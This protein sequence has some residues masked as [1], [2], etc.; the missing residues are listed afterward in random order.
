MRSRLA[1]GLAV[2]LAACSDGGSSG[3]TIPT[4]PWANFRHDN[5][6]SAL[7]GTI[8]RNEGKPQLLFAA[9]EGA[10]TLS[11]PAIDRDGN[12]LLATDNGVMSLDQDGKVRWTFEGYSTADA[13]DTPCAVCTLDIPGCIP[14]GRVTASP[15]VSP[16]NTII[17]GTEGPDGRLFAI[18]EQQPDVECNWIFP[19]AD[20]PGLGFKSS[21]AVIINTLDL[22]LQSVFVGADDG[23]LRSLNA[24]G[25]VRWS[26]ATAGPI[27]ASPTLD[28][29]LNTY[30]TTADGVIP[31]V[32]FSGA[33]FPNP[34]SI[35]RPPEAP[36]QPSP[37]ASFSLYAVG[38]GGSLFAVSPPA[39]RKWQFT[40]PA[41]SVIRG[42]PAFVGQS[43]SQQSETTFDTIVYV[44]DTQGT[45]FGV[46]D[47]N[48][49]LLQLQR[50]PGG[51]DDPDPFTQD[52]RMD[53]CEPGQGECG[54]NNRCSQADTVTCTRDSCETNNIG[55]CVLLPL[56]RDVEQGVPC[57]NT[58]TIPSAPATTI[59]ASP[60][61]SNDQFVV[62]G[63][64]DGR[65][66]AR[67]L[68]NLVPG[69]TLDNPTGTW[70][71]GE[72]CITLDPT[73]DPSSPEAA[74]RSSPIIG[75][76]G[77]IYVTTDAGLWVIE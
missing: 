51:P 42:S 6:N 74:T 46:R 50:C 40:P 10:I 33:S 64:S 37:A 13:P 23:L 49:L 14:V 41:T 35:G 34:I 21:A 47:A 4:V 11:T 1:L 43:F 65:I 31:A 32:S 16:G 3:S 19:A 48:G 70:R 56:C 76:N 24:D 52:C 5:S 7:G 71:D 69:Q 44:V 58:M 59:A 63:T 77:R 18:Q 8:Q 75:Q 36:F 68:D 67:T 17:F 29:N 53:S 55:E 66:C 62:V 15:T 20:A 45:A 25:T 61:L 54:N 38:S 72:G 73:V 2:L 27:T 22:S 26:V 57:S 12:L 30:V 9:A 60:V 39:Q 28:G